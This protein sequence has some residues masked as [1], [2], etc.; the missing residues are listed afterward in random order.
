VS[1]E[2]AAPEIDA[3]EIDIPKLRP[4]DAAVIGD[5]AAEAMDSAAS[6]EPQT[7]GKAAQF[8]TQRPPAPASTS[9]TVTTTTTAAAAGNP[10]VA[11]PAGGERIPRIAP[12]AF[13]F[14][15]IPS[16]AAQ[17]IAPPPNTVTIARTHR[18]N[19]EAHLAS[20]PPTLAPAKVDVI[21]ERSA[22][23]RSRSIGRGL[24]RLAVDLLEDLR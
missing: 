2:I 12:A 24:A 5:P 1:P 22:M 23:Y 19:A 14:S 21:F 4:L 10:R 15:A 20:E 16:V 18:V 7:E 6:D 9:T 11:S 17:S 8:T 13:H 3:A